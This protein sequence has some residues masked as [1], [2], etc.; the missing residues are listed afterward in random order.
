[1]NR[2]NFINCLILFITAF[3]IGFFNQEIIS[4]YANPRIYIGLLSGIIAVMTVIIILQAFKI[5]RFTSMAHY[6]EVSADLNE[7]KDLITKK[8]K[9]N[10]QRRKQNR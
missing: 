10:G 2:R 8:Q 5:S 3:L 9:V 7:I 1:M 6:W 4:C